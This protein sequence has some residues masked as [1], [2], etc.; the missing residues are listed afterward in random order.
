MSYF[1]LFQI[2]ALE[3]FANLKLGLLIHKIKNDPANITTIFSGSLSLASEVHSYS[4]R[5]ATNFDI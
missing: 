1:N 4:T 2:L 3:N 5:F